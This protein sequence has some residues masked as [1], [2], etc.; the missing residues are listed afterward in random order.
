[1][2]IREISYDT[3]KKY[4]IAIIELIIIYNARA[5]GW[6]IEKIGINEYKLYK[7]IEHCA[8]FSLTTFIKEVTYNIPK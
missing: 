5:K 1:M 8:N 7:K 4:L 2:D 3:I 6:N